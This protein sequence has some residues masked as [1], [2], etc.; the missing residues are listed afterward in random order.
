MYVSDIH[1]YVFML[2]CISLLAQTLLVFKVIEMF[3]SDS[4]IFLY[5]KYPM[6][7]HV[8]SVFNHS[9]EKY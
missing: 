8:S 2:R 3:C 4:Y 9:S 6:G 7:Y 5:K 1:V